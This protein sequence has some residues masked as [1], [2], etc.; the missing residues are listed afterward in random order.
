LPIADCRLSI[1]GAKQHPIGNEK[2]AIGN[3]F[4]RT[5]TFSPA[6]QFKLIEAVNESE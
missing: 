5:V 4:S 2:S 1:D 3:V 6:R